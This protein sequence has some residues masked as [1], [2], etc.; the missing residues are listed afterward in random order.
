MRIK[1]HIVSSGVISFMVY[2]ISR[3]PVNGIVSFLAGVFIDLDHIVDYY[4]NYGVNYKLKEVY[5]TLCE[6]RLD[7]FY[8]FLHSFELLVIFWILI[9]LIPLNNIFCAIA[10][11]FTQHV[12]LDQIH[13]PIKPRAYFL[14]YRIANKFSRE[15]I[16]DMSRVKNS[17]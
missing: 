4:L 17:P 9:F 3:S 13:N 8:V 14:A 7:K 11:G 16:I 6:S 15:A 1:G 10:I 5:V 12:F 2:L